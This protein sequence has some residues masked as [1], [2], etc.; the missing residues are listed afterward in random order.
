MTLMND[1]ISAQ[2]FSMVRRV[3]AGDAIEA[4]SALADRALSASAPEVL[5]SRGTPY[6]V[7]NLLEVAPGL[8]DAALDPRLTD[9]VGEILGAGCGLVRSV[10]FD[11][12]PDRGWS[13][14]WHQDTVIAVRDNRL[15]S[16]AFCHP[17]TKLGVPHVEAP[18]E[19]LERMLIARVHLDD[20]T[21]E[22]G[23]L[24]VIPGSHGGAEWDA[25]RGVALLAR[26]GD[27]LYIRPLVAHRSGKPRGRGSRRRVLHFD[28]AA[29]DALP[30]GYEW[31]Q[32]VA[33]VRSGGAGP[34]NS[35][36]WE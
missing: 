18:R 34:T 32:F 30:H 4:L 15:P 26:A 17:T 23:P 14:P 27:V 7:R 3:F 19:V 28:Y 13:L 22:N 33:V 20:M 36:S 21:E 31:H 10:L 5:R 25:G 6:A 16:S 12:P 11:K 35:K 9:L 1:E 8:R 2:G 24:E 29:A